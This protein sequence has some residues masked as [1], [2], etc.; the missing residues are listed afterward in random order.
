MAIETH[1]KHKESDHYSLDPATDRR[2]ETTGGIRRG[3]KLLD[4][5]LDLKKKQRGKGL[6]PRCGG[7][8]GTGELHTG[9]TCNLQNGGRPRRGRRSGKNRKEKGH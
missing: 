1:K 7:P 8:A 6:L 5:L 4:R 9:A 3:V 2:S